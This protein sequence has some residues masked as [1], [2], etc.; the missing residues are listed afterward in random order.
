MATVLLSQHSSNPLEV[1]SSDARNKAYHQEYITAQNTNG[2][3]TLTSEDGY[4][5]LDRPEMVQYHNHLSRLYSKQGVMPSTIK[6][7]PHPDELPI[8]DLDES[9]EYTDDIHFEPPDDMGTLDD[10]DVPDEDADVDGE[11]DEEK[12][13]FLKPPEEQQEIRLEIANINK[14]VPSLSEDYA[15]VDRLGT[16]TFSSVYKAIDLAYHSKWDNTTWHGYHPPITPSHYQSVR[17]HPGSKVFVAIKRIYVT[18][19]PER[20]RNEISIMEDCRGCRHTSQLITAFRHHD[21]VVAIMPYSRNDDLRVRKLAFLNSHEE[22]TL[23]SVQDYYKDL[24]M[25]GIKAYFR[26]MFR[27]LRDIHARGIIHR[28]V[29]PANFLFDPRTG[30]G[31]LCDF[32]LASVRY[33][34]WTS[35]GSHNTMFSENGW[36]DAG[37]WCLLTYVCHTGSS[38]RQD[39]RAE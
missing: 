17:Y 34:T 18:S 26:C 23:T 24:S 12:T 11:T 6:R 22:D 3:F 7:K 37:S 39:K 9:M 13:L 38:S 35:G 33:E 10:D 25:A 2:H 16:G 5:G 1:G 20:I 36:I 21:Q 30:V 8:V 28:D 4:Y 19:N 31:A 15:I 29:K 32:G 27:A 14:A